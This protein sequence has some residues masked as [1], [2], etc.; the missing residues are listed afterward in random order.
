M[1]YPRRALAFLL[2]AALGSASASAQ[3]GDPV[4]VEED[5]VEVEAALIEAS[6]LAN[7]GDEEAAVELYQKLLDADPTNTA[8]AYSASR[9]LRATDEERALKLM[10]QAR[11]HDPDNAY[12]LQALADQLTATGRHL[13]AADVYAE[14]FGRS[15]RRTEFLLEQTQ[16]LAQ[17]GKAREGLRVVERYLSG[18]GRLTPFIGQHRFTLAVS[19]NDPR[20]AVKA[21]EELMAAYPDNPE[22]YQE[23]AQFYRRTGDEASAKSVWTQM[24]ER[25]PDDRRAQLGLAGQSKLTGEEESFIVRLEPI[26]ADPALDIDAK[27]LQLMPIVQE[28]ASRSDTVLANRVLP[29]SLT[30]TEVHPDEPKAFAIHADLLLQARRPAEAVEAYRATLALDP[31]VYLVWDQLLLAL[32]ETAQYEELLEESENALALFPNQARL[33]Y[34]NGRALANT[35]DLT[36]AENTLLQGA[37]LALD[38]QVLLYDMHEAL[39]RVQ[40]RSARFADARASAERALEVRPKYGPALATL[41]EVALREGDVASAKPVLAQAVA[42]SPQH[43]YVLTVEALAQSL[44]GDVD[45]AQSTLDMAFDKGADT[46]AVA[47]ELRG[48]IAFLQGDTAAAKAAWQQARTLGGGSHKLAEKLR[49][50]A[51]V[52]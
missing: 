9:L 47:H 42:E 13:Q 18:G 45:R 50:G 25:F 12:V 1:T 38:D 8:A 20:A 28:V 46:W 22:Y 7:Q 11:R 17:G 31:S 4:Q 37:M 52:K 43:P 36:A 40:L 14:L 39:A 33:Y 3:G 34:Y 27:V 32:A 35:G 19:L 15:P 49:A 26:F 6:G 51:Y 44:D 41:A 5:V 30:L 29:L 24:A 10:Q 2:A 21:L 23:L 48:D 16:A